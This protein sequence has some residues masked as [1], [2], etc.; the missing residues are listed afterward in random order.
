MQPTAPAREVTINGGARGTA[1]FDIRHPDLMG[2]R[3]VPAIGESVSYL[4]SLLKQEQAAGTP[5]DR[6]VIGGFSQVGHSSKNAPGH[7]TRVCGLH[8]CIATCSQ[9]SHPHRSPLTA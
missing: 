4:T 3:D 1:W 6:I 9:V 7:S 2:M 5:A 8:L